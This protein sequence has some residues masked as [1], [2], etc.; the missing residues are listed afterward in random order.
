MQ[1]ETELM[2]MPE[3]FGPHY[4]RS[5]VTDAWEPLYSRRKNG[6]VEIGL[7]VGNPHTNSRGFLHGGVLAA[8]ADNA[9]GLSYHETRV[10]LLGEDEAIKSALT[11]N[12]SIDFVS[13]ARVGAWLQITPRVL[14]GGR[15]TGFVD[16]TVTADNEII[17]RASAIFRA[18]DQARQAQ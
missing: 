6:I 16:A 17:A 7:V 8:L 1:I 18:L 5:P 2:R 11:V 12:L 14:R 3:G 10:L 9:M 4:R 15:A 13:T